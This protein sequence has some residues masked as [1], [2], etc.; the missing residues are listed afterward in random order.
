M[1]GFS[2]STYLHISVIIH[3]FSHEKTVLIIVSVLSSNLMES[4]HYEAVLNE[5]MKFTMLLKLAYSFGCRIG[6]FF[7]FNNPKLW[8]IMEISEI[9][10]GSIQV[11]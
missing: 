8:K 11:L 10:G 3:I 5:F 2:G 9:G 4:L 7:I 1:H 6:L